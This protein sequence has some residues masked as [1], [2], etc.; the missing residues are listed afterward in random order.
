ML[1]SRKKLTSQK[2]TTEMNIAPGT[3]A[4]A[5]F[6][7]NSIIELETALTGDADSSEMLYWD[8]TAEEWVNH[9][10]SALAALKEL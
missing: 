1:L 7:H 6:E 3:F 8:I 4:E 9:I 2:R 10:K 5:C